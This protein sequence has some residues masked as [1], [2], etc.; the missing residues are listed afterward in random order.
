VSA[1]CDSLLLVSEQYYKQIQSLQGIISQ[2][3]EQAEVVTKSSPASPLKWL[4][5]GLALG[6]IGGL[7]FRPALKKLVAIIKQE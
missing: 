2:Q 4:F 7:S 3:M 5:V 6:A 1:V